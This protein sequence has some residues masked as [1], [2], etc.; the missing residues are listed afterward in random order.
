MSEIASCGGKIH[1][2]SQCPF[3]Q[4]S[5]ALSNDDYVYDKEPVNEEIEMETKGAENEPVNV[6]VEGD[7]KR[8]VLIQLT[9][10]EACSD[11][12]HQ[13]IFMTSWLFYATLFFDY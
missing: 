12:W 11:W 3:Q 9:L 13:E 10:K 6:T 1:P 4:V 2:A 8:N 7:A 5:I